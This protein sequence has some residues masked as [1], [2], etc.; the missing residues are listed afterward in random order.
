MTPTAEQDQVVEAVRGGDTVKVKAYA[1]AGKTSTLRMAAEARGR[2]RGLYL[3]FNKDIATEAASKFPQ[4]TRCR[5]VHSLA[6]GATRPEITRKLKNPVEP[7][8]Q[9]ALR[10]GFGKL[11]LPTTIGKDLELSPGK[12]ARMVMDGVARFCGSAQAEPLAWHIPVD[13]IVK[14]EDAERLR[15]SLLPSVRKLWEEY[16]DPASPSAISHGVY[17]KLWERSRPRIGADFILFD[18]AQDADGLM[19]SVLRAQQ[20][21]VIYVGD[22]YQ[23]IYE[24][25]GAVNAMDHIRAPE[26]A[27]TESFRFGPAIAQLASRMLQLM[28]E[29]T[30]VRGQE[31][32][33]SRILH[34]SVPG[35]DRFDAILCRKNA[36]V[37]THLAQ[38]I[39][40]GDRVAVRAKVDE[41]QAF[42]DGAEQLMHGQRVA[43]PATLA[44]F[45]SWDE[46]QEYADSFA[47]RD[48]KPL[49]KLI[50]DE[51]VDYLRLILTR[52]SPENE[53]DYIVSTVH[54]AK[55]LEWDRVQLAGDFKFKHGDDGKMT[56]TAEEKRL[57]YVAI[58]RA[59]HLLD[60]SEIRRDLYTMFRDAGV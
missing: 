16:I 55:G 44:L 36:T 6:F 54:R 10:Y 40:R 29:H 18:E 17:V 31:H 33:S 19:L 34:E 32:V 13:A 12:V 35:R 5:T 46:V 2:A 42:A 60:I 20:A 41:L 24:W 58:S 9:L 59:K 51:G 21:Q 4:N 30:P 7:P 53:A 8:H 37:L 49:V 50:D 3:A 25:R 23:Q 57:L 39:G 56:M 52:V 11:R 38:G 27:L 22:P 14:E 1:G 26:C 28:D 45:E 43:Y 48:L 47:G 15:E